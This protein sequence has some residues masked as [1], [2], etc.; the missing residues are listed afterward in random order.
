MSSSAQG[1]RPRLDSAGAGADN[2]GAAVKS[3]GRPDQLFF[4]SASASVSSG[5][6]VTVSRWQV[7]L[8][9]VLPIQPPEKMLMVSPSFEYTRITADVPFDTPE[10]LYRV[11]INLMWLQTLNDRWSLSLAVNPSLSADS[12]AF[13][14][15]IQ[16]FGLAALRWEQKPDRLWWTF[17]AVHTGRSDIPVLPALGFRWTPS[18]RWDVNIMMPRPKV[19]FR[20]TTDAESS[21]WIYW[22][23]ALGGGT[24]DVERDDGAVQE[25]SFREFQT[26]A[27]YEYRISRFKNLFAEVGAAF[28]RRLEYEEAGIEESVGEGLFVRCG[29]TF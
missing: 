24:W 6:D 26:V 7:G 12:N 16:L 5:T 2:A 21:T 23:G 4:T 9:T 19:S 27:G 22:S 3:S 29:L 1:Q 11:G 17:G 8:R 15:S 18:E 10:D 20:L 13:G 25:F 14:E 28:G